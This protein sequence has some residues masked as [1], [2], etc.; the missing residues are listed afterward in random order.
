MEGCYWC[1]GE[2]EAKSVGANEK[3]FCPADCGNESISALRRFGRNA[4][5]TGKVSEPCDETRHRVFVREVPPHM[6]TPE[7]GFPDHG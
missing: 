4:H 6:L 2:F 1:V 7:N 5:D 3:K